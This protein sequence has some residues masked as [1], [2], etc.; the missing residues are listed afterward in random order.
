MLS[1]LSTAV[2]SACV[3]DTHTNAQTFLSTHYHQPEADSDREC[4]AHSNDPRGV[5]NPQSIYQRYKGLDAPPPLLPL[6]LLPP[7]CCC[8]HRHS[9]QPSTALQ[10]RFTRTRTAPAAA[11]TST[12]T[13]TTAAAAAV[14]TT[15]SAAQPTP[16]LLLILLPGHGRLLLAIQA[17]P[18]CSNA[19]GRPVLLGRRW[20]Q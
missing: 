19:L 3:A 10:Q 15:A 6:L 7:K 14:A 18:Q 11:S 20:R 17:E 1:L 12:A 5:V 9:W 4:C 2:W 16:L 13:T 8:T